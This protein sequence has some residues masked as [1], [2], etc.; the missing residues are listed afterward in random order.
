MLRGDQR[1]VLLQHGG[2]D[3]LTGKTGLAMLR[4]RS[5]PVVAVIDPDHAGEDLEAITGMARDVPVVADLAS[6]LP[7]KPEVAVV[8]LA[9]SGG[10]LPEDVRADVLAALQAGLSIASGLHTRLDDDPS[11]MQRCSLDVGSGIYAGNPRLCRRK[12]A[13]PIWAADVCCRWHGRCVGKMS[14]C[15]AVHEAAPAPA[16]LQPWSALARQ[17]S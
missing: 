9:P 5:G 17:G 4:Y 11:C 10:V 15:L 13:L 6:A 14:A 7:F 1:I 16:C 12:R 3:S 8:G 2:L